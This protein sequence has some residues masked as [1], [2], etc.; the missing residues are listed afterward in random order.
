MNTAQALF[1]DLDRT[2]LDGSRF[3]ES[4]VATCEKIAA[5]RPDLAADRLL[6]ANG[7]VFRD[8]WPQVE[9][10][11]TLGHL[12]GA[13]FMLETWRRTLRACGS[14]DDALAR[15]ATQT[16]LQLGR[17]TYRL[18]DDARALLSSLQRARMPLALITNGAS[19][20]QRDKLRSLGIEDR[21]DA[22]VIS[23][24]VGIAK[25]DPSLFELA[26]DKLAVRREHAWH[27]GD[28]LATDVAGAQAAGLT[29]VWLNRRGL[30]RSAGDPEPDFE[31]RSLSDL[32]ALLPLNQ[33]E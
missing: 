21:F 15:F 20:T 14:D 19:D 30:S 28:N 13:S 27:V 25:P 6:E 16:H 24:D 17:E 9:K 10:D 7:E 26:L 18:Y 11:W 33:P 12:D 3:Q 4:I 22:V 2:L 1:L 8:Y 31:I 29:A 32:L 5:R 23:G